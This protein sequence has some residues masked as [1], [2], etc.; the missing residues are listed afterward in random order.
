MRDWREVVRQRV[1]TARL[2]PGAEADRVEE[3]AQHLEQR[4]QDL[5]GTGVAPEVAER[6]VLAELS[7]GDDA[8]PWARS[9]GRRRFAPPAVGADRAGNV[10]RGVGSDL[11][12]AFRMLA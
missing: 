5:V 6:E 2:S 8:A 10:L 12:I 4:Y 9:G 11:R 1:A 7:N 3:I